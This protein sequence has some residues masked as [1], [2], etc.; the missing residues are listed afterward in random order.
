MRIMIA[1]GGTGGHVF[2][3]IAIAEQFKKQSTPQEIHEI[4]FIGTSAGMENKLVPK[5]GFELRTFTLGKLV[6]QSVLHRLKTLLQLPRA[7]LFCMKQIRQFKADAVIGVGGYAAGPCIVGAR[8]LRVP[9]FVLEQNSVAGFTNKIAAALSEKVFLAFDEIPDGIAAA[10]SIV[11]GNPARSLMQPKEKLNQIGAGKFTVFAFGGSQGATG[12]NKLMVEAAEWLKANDPEN[13]GRFS[14][15]HQTGE[16][17]LAW[18]RQAYEKLQFPAVA[19]AFIYK[20]QEMYDQSDIVVARAGSGTISELAA[21]Q[22]AAIFVPFPFAA[23]NHQEKNARI[24]ESRG[25]A[26]VFTQGKT[27]GAELAQVF[28]NFLKNPGALQGLRGNMAKFHK[29]DAAKDIVHT[30]LSHLAGKTVRIQ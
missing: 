25:A 18:V 16:R 20:M 12:I 27:N 3:G 23:G 5:A 21:T 6:G 1:G 17:D 8:I 13:L 4:L 19:E 22:N 15:L 11:T 30:V 28:L 26:L 14:F 10:K 29:P 2:G 9:C 24:L 7:I